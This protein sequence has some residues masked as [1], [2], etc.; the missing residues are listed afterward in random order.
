VAGFGVFVACGYEEEVD[1]T[2]GKMSDVPTCGNLDQVPCEEDRKLDI[3]EEVC[4]PFTDYCHTVKSTI[5][6]EP[7][8]TCPL[9]KANCQ[10]VG[11]STK[12]SRAKFC[13]EPN[14][15]NP[16]ESKCITAGYGH[17]NEECSSEE[18]CVIDASL[19]ADKKKLTCDFASSDTTGLTG[20]KKAE[21]EARAK[22]GICHKCGD[23]NQP[24]CDGIISRGCNTKNLYCSFSSANDKTG[25]C[26]ECGSKDKQCCEGDTCNDGFECVTPTTRESWQPEKQCKQK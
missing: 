9:A 16:G 2:R 14:K 1:M 23:L 3:E 6:C 7:N 18:P 11:D 4:V 5:T 17:L 26:S 25:K 12:C 10:R 13:N 15:L 20:K 24:C 22:F 19:D 8:R 21:A